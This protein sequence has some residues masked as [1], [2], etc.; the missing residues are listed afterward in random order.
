MKI[1]RREML[2]YSGVLAAPYL[3]TFQTVNGLFLDNVKEEPKDIM[4]RAVE[5]ATGRGAS[6]ADARLTL[7]QG[8]VVWASNPPAREAAM[9]FGVRVL[10]DGYWG[11]AS[12]PV[13]TA[14][15]AERLTISA[16]EQAASNVS[17]GERT[18]DMGTFDNP[19]SGEWDMPVVYDPFTIPFEEIS[20]YLYGIRDFCSSLKW[21]KG[22]LMCNFMTVEKYFH[23]S[24]GQY[25]RQKLYSTHGGFN[26]MVANRVTRRQAV[27]SIGDKITPAGLGFEYFRDRPIR[28]YI[29][30]AHEDA[31]RDLELPIN[32]V[33]IGRWNILIGSWGMSGLLS[34]TLGDAT[35]LD[36]SLGF[37]ANSGGTSYINE[38][39]EML[40]TLKIGSELLNVSS[41]R[42][43][44]GSVGKVL[45]DDEGVAPRKMSLIDK[46]I[47]RNMHTSRELCSYIQPYYSRNGLKLDPSGSVGAQ[48]AINVPLIYSSDLTLQPGEVASKSLNDL[49]EEMKTGIEFKT[50]GVQMDFQKVTGYITGHTYKINNGKR[51]AILSDVGLIFRTQELWNNLIALGGSASVWKYGIST[52]KG[53][54][55]QTSRHQVST[56]PSIFKEL[57]I[58]DITRK[59]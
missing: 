40:G 26:G 30:E 48:S 2:Q 47:L 7:N 49:R 14:A 50:A 35:Q 16:L 34:E 29:E 51:T 8:M 21:M 42:S 33:D 20:D 56:P 17:G 27:V 59:A 13:W 1:S 44:A 45:W 15:E 19:Q 36:R 12:S 5:V 6:Y 23:S 31:L 11:F 4:K 52:R 55:S 43:E 10:V 57:S 32:P 28:Q 53:E 46:G 41:D 54:P 58:I 38:P 18:V 3:G 39:L 37:E 24:T 25:T 9:C 22:E